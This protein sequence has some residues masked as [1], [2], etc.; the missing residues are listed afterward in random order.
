M[1]IL[2]I[3]GGDKYS[4]DLKYDHRISGNIQNPHFLKIEFQMVQFSN[5][6]A[7][8][9]A[10]PFENQTIQNPIVLSGLGMF[11]DKMAAICQDIEWLGF[12][13]SDTI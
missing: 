8:A 6:L 1:K 11:F 10:Q 7:L 4:G 13:I 12:Q 2:S 5:S 3:L 9:L